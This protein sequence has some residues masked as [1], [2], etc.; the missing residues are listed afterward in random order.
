MAWNI[1][2]LQLYCCSVLARHLHQKGQMVFINYWKV[3]SILNDQDL[4]RLIC[5]ILLLELYIM[6][7]GVCL[8]VSDT[9]ACK[10]YTSENILVFWLLDYMHWETWLR[11]H[12]PVWPLREFVPQRVENGLIR[13]SIWP[14][15]NWAVTG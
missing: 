14:K 7:K 2:I 4:S 9:A 10:M 1:I 5:S 11:W 15:W 6:L 3:F 8:H 12:S 13:V